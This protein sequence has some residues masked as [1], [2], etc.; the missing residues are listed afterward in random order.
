MNIIRKIFIFILAAAG[1]A[2]IGYLANL[3]SGNPL[4]TQ[5]FLGLLVFA[6][7]LFLRTNNGRRR[8]FKIRKK[9]AGLQRCFQLVSG[10][11]PGVGVS[12]PVSA[13]D[14][15]RDYGKAFHFVYGRAFGLC[16]LARRLLAVRCL[17]RI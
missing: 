16:S 5:S 1:T 13:N 6:A 4:F 7:L 15:R 3:A 9:A 14:I 2:G 8:R 11:D 17:R 12:D 10:C